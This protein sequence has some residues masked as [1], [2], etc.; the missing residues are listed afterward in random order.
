MDNLHYHGFRYYQRLAAEI[1]WKDFYE[2]GAV[3][4]AFILTLGIG[5]IL[6]GLLCAHK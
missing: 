3:V 5:I 4:L 1:K 2:T 6:G